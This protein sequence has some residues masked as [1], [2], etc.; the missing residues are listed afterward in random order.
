M[1]E[2]MSKNG[3]SGWKWAKINV[4]ERK[5][6]KVSESGCV[7]KWKWIKMSVSK[8]SGEIN[9][10]YQALIIKK[11]KYFFYTSIKIKPIVN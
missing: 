10:P 11:T 6:G 3:W 1:S 8:V 2:N 5:W 9:I 4:G 7:K